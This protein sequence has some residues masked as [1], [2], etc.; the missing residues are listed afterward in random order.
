[1]TDLTPQ[2]QAVL[3]LIAANPFAGQAEIATALGLARS[4]VAQHVAA[5]G[6]KGRILGRGYVLAPTGRVVT[7]GGAALDRKYVGRAALV[8]ETSN[9]VDGHRSF[10][11]VARNVTENLAR[12]GVPVAFLSA[13]GDDD[14][15]RAL[16]AD[17]RNL[18]VD[19]SATLLVPGRATAEY[20]AILEP[21][22]RLRLGLADM[23][24]LDLLTPAALDR[25][26]AQLA[27]AS[28][29]FADCNLPAVTLAVLRTRRRGGGFRLAVD[30][31]STPKVARLGGDLAGIDLLFLNL[32]EARALTGRPT[33]DA[34]TAAAGLVAAGVGAVVLTLGAA[35]ALVVD[36]DGGAATVAALPAHQV[37]A[38]GAGDAL[39]AATLA[40]LADGPAVA[41][42]E[43]AATGMVA[44]AL[45][46]ESD[47]SVRPD[48]GRALVRDAAAA[49]R[50]GRRLPFS[51]DIDTD[52]RGSEP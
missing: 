25:A 17:L 1:M 4:T 8:D 10:G 30:A 45:T 28:W 48:L 49:R 38:T 19:T 5:L 20:V 52:T 12:L 13:T 50:P 16:L 27:A 11:G 43:A 41:V 39:I 22:G 40:E 51:A 31:V 26:A 35:G 36:G 46:I 34:A 3:D 18:G 47:A 29:V 42:A 23:S 32:D 21:D 33:A 6:R 7:I 37:D 9:P 44:A 2:E 14:T 24:V 15:G